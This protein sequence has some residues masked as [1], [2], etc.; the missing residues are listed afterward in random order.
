MPSIRR[1]HLVI[2]LAVLLAAVGLFF[3]VRA[4][5]GGEPA[6]A[7]APSEP[8]ASPSPDPGAQPFQLKIAG[9]RGVRIDSSNLYGREAPEKPDVV[10]DAA[11]RAGEELQRYL[12][13]QFIDPKTR[14]TEQPLRELFTPLAFSTLDKDDR[15]ALGVSSLK[16]LGGE[17]SKATARATVMHL[18]DDPYAVTL[19]YR[20][21]TKLILSDDKPHPVVQEGTM[22]FAPVEGGGWRA[23][24]ADVRLSLPDAPKQKKPVQPQ[25]SQEPTEEA[26]P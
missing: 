26:S 8:A 3:A 16:V 10:K 2:G 22:V 20:A 21:T 15:A 11:T 17:D 6:A 4:M 23:D 24:M 13:A 1:S 18:G 25:P 12:N 19:K 14:F 9:A 5:S 7:P